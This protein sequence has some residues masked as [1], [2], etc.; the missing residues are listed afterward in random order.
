VSRTTVILVLPLISG[1]FQFCTLVCRAQGSEIS[2]SDMMDLALLS[3][4]KQRYL[5]NPLVSS[6]NLTLV[7]RMVLP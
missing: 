6:H 2:D 7:C 3:G 5:L 1:F 4:A